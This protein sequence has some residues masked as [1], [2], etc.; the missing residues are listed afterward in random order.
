MQRE[1]ERRG[2]GGSGP[3]QYELRKSAGLAAAER[4][5]AEA[6]TA[7]REQYREQLRA[8]KKRI[9]DSL[10]HRKSLI[11]RHDAVICLLVSLREAQN[12]VQ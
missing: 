2:G 5:A 9:A 1:A 12:V 11:E 6:A 7:A 4:K 3:G 8:N 10:A